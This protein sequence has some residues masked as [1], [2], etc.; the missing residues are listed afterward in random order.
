M[1]EEKPN[2]IF[3][4]YLKDELYRDHRKVFEAMGQAMKVQETDNQL[5]GVGFS[6]TRRNDIIVKVDNKVYK[7][8]F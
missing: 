7:I 3:N 1:S 4:E 6:L 8:N 2:A 5:S